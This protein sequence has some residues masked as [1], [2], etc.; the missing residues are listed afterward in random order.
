MAASN[1]PEMIFKI[2][3]E[4]RDNI[5]CSDTKTIMFDTNEEEAVAIV[6]FGGVL[7]YWNYFRTILLFID[8]LTCT[9]RI[10]S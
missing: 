10:Y 1:V 9:E 4:S 2:I 8:K 5:T 7:S 3:L 6:T